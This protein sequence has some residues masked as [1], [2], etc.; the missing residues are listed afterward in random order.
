MITFSLP[1]K[2]V[3]DISLLMQVRNQPDSY[4]VDCGA[5]QGFSIRQLQRVRAVFISHTH[6]DHWIDFDTLLR[7]QVQYPKEVTICGPAG[8]TDRVHAKLQAYNWNLLDHNAVTYR[9]HEIEDC[10]RVHISRLAPPR[11]V[12]KFET[13]LENGVPYRDESVQVTC[14]LL[15]HQIPSVAYCFTTPERIQLRLEDS[16]YASGPWA[17][18][19][20]AAFEADEPQRPLDIDG[21]TQPAGS[22]FHLLQRLPGTKVG[23]VLDHAITEA[24]HQA[25]QSLFR[26]ADAVYIES[27]FLEKDRD[28]ALRKAHSTAVASAR[29]LSG[30]GIRQAY[31]I[32]HSRKYSEA[33]VLRLHKEFYQHFHT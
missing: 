1:R 17:G 6:V 16:P 5:L 12:P 4:L 21:T 22:L 33:E 9:V 7:H 20:K 24:N 29:A 30:I 13:I 11:Y 3:P 26:D 28:M 23:V 25:I 27:Y 32:H 19:L 2:N 31:P 8:I 10:E 15:D 14:T 18:E